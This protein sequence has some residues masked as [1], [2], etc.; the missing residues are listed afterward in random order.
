MSCVNTPLAKFLFSVSLC[1]KSKQFYKKIQ[2]FLFQDIW[3][4]ILELLF[5]TIFLSWCQQQR[6]DTNPGH[7][8]GE[9]SVLPLC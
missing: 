6:L 8:D 1:A 4:G 9:A 5:W 3:Q 2:K 7:W